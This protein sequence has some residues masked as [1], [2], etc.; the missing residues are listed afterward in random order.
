MTRRLEWLLAGALILALPAWGREAASASDDPALEA[1]VMRVASE[2][3][4]LVCQNETIAASQ[5][6]LAVDL[7]RQVREML[8]QGKTEREIYAFMTERYGNFVLYRPPLQR[9]T[10]LLWFGP[11]VLC[12]G[13]LLGL[14][15]LL[16]RRSQLPADR[17]EPDA[18]GSR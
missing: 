17:F 8:G 10:V 5:A 6:D 9:N 16:R 15:W 13:G 4:C 2:L 1:R 3:R 14:W 18:D 7:R 11:A 12:G